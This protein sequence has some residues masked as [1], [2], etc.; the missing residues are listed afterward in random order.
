MLNYFLPL[1][2]GLT[3]PVVKASSIA[4]YC[5]D[6]G[7]MEQLTCDLAT[8]QRN[9]NLKKIGTT[10]TKMKNLLGNRVGLPAPSEEF[11][12]VP[13]TAS[14]LKMTEVPAA[15]DSYLRRMERDSWWLSYRDPTTLNSPLR[16]LSSNITGSLAAKRAGVKNGDRLLKVAEGAADYLIWAQN[17]GGKGVFPFPH[18]TQDTIYSPLIEDVVTLAQAQGKSSQVSVNGWIVDDLGLGHLQYDNGLAGVALLELYGETGEQKYLNA[19]LSA[20]NWTLAQPIVPNWNYNSFSVF[21]LSKAYQV[22]GDPRYLEDAKTRARLGIYPG[23]LTKGERQGYWFDHHNAQLVYHYIL[24]RG[25]GSL[26]AVLPEGDPEFNKALESLSLALQEGNEEIRNQGITNPE[27]LLEVL[28][29]LELDLDGKAGDLV[30]ADDEATLDLVERYVSNQFYNGR[31]SV[32]PVAWG[33]Y[34]ENLSRQNTPST[35]A[36][37][38]VGKKSEWSLSPTCT[39]QNCTKAQSTPE[40]GTSV[41][42]VLFGLSALLMLRS[43]RKDAR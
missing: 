11:Q 25:L 29:R 21:F 6:S 26:V 39:A 43:R 1:T 30:D 16:S 34:L 5:R 14:Q 22:T 9:K 38:F 36:Q 12:K 17:Q 41:P 40:P 33:L 15:F 7:T 2:L 37:L 35:T 24:I 10:T 19:A 20:A 8:A 13:S 42:L 27:T 31:S 23:Q 4:A 18:L 28:S 32:G 3:A